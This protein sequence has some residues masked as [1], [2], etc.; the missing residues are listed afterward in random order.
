MGWIYVMPL[1]KEPEGSWENHDVNTTWSNGY[2]TNR[3]TKATSLMQPI[4]GPGGSW[5][6]DGRGAASWHHG[7]P[8]HRPS[9]I[10][11]LCSREGGIQPRD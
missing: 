9:K 4:K 1:P 7:G 8:P 6:F 3:E 5:L 11:W 10:E 2:W